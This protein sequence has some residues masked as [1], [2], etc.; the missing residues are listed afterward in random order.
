MFVGDCFTMTNEF[1]KG[2]LSNYYLK[3]CFLF[4]KLKDL[5]LT[6]EKS[7]DDKTCK[8]FS[9]MVKHDIEF[10]R[11][12]K[13]LVGLGYILSQNKVDLKDILKQRMRRFNKYVNEAKRICKVFSEHGIRF[14]LIKTFGSFPKD[15]GDLDILLY[16]DDLNDAEKL[17]SSAGYVSRK[18]GLRQYLWS[19]RKDDVIVDVELHTKISAADYE[20][21]PR[22]RVFKRA[23]KCCELI[24]PSYIDSLLILA[25]H[26]VMKD[27]FITAADLLD[28]VITLQKYRIDINELI[29]EANFLG[30]TLPLNTVLYIIKKLGCEL[31]N[32]L[33]RELNVTFGVKLNDIVI[34]PP[35]HIV[36]LSYLDMTVK[37]AKQKP[38][39]NMLEEIF[40]LPR[41]KGIDIFVR[42]AG[43]K[44]PLVKKFTE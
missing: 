4:N 1:Q 26:A 34:R 14:V 31:E 36:L 33:R 42:F 27:L 12:N 22:E 15:L 11:Y 41:S 3:Y 43:S 37:K 20:Y 19:L 21:Y 40:S 9:L 32:N 2:L 35:F 23:V 30:L 44:K 17:L 6:E 38:L 24:L 5:Y 7:I 8:L 29:N 28:F 18:I 39:M 13:L 16:D 10:L 25:G